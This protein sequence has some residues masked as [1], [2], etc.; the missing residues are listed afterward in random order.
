MEDELRFV[1]K[2]RDLT[3]NRASELKYRLSSLGVKHEMELQAKEMLEKRLAVIVEME[4]KDVSDEGLEHDSSDTD[5][6][7]PH[8]D[9]MS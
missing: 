2:D 1:D 3:S 7:D 6:S 9:I 8:V 4:N 5:G